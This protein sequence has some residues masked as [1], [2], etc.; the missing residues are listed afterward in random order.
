[1]A[2]SRLTPVFTDN[3]SRNL[4]AIQVFLGAAGRGAFERLLD[5]LLDD[6]IPMLC[7]FPD[8]GPSLLDR[9]AGSIEAVQ[10]AKRLQERLKPGDAIREFLVDDSLLLSL[11][12]GNRLFFLA[13]K[14]HR[15]LSFDLPLFWR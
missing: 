6:I 11:R 12:R 1:M 2:D 4:D 3:L 15:Q 10:Q 13:I 8:S 9:A 5:R 7:Q 14:H